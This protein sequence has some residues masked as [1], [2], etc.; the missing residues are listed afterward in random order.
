MKELQKI[1][2]NTSIR[3]IVKKGEIWV[4]VKD[5]AEALGYQ[6]QPNLVNHVPYE[7]KGINPINTPGGIQDMLCLSEQGLYFFLG[8]S[9][10][11]K[12]LPFQQWIA[13]EVVPSIRKTGKYEI[14]QDLKTKSVEARKG[15]AGEWQRQ[16]F[17]PVD[18]IKATKHEYKLLFGNGNLKKTEMDRK[19]IALLS[20]LEILELVELADYENNELSG[21][22][23]IHHMDDK[24]VLLQPPTPDTPYKLP[25]KPASSAWAGQD[26]Y[27]RRWQVELFFKWIK[28]NLKINS[29]WGTSENAVFTQIWVA[30]IVS[31][32]LWI[33]KTVNG[34][35]ASAHQILQMMKSTL[36]SKSSIFELWT[37]K[38]PPP[39]PHSPQPL[40]EGL[41]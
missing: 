3:T 16:R 23:T 31:V 28:Q 41:L 29:F 20:A 8:R 14:P 39:T 25:F 2:E 36:L 4:V 18:F 38:P 33:I 30:L 15:I 1:Y 13:G 40:L 5:A 19:R 6:W 10:K 7:W 12:A 11:P 21:S 9:D 17:K 26:I 24:P 27:K 22:D 32:L 34:I 35:T 37:N